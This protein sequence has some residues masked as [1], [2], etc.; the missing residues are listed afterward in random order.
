MTPK[1][2]QTMT[3]HLNGGSKFSRMVFRIDADGVDTG[4]T[5][6]KETSGSPK[7]LITVDGFYKG[8]DVFDVLAT[9]GVGMME[10][11]LARIP[12]KNGEA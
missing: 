11:I 7:Y 2:T 3:M 5:R 8:D 6:I 4:I 1:V 9:K 10:W 12:E